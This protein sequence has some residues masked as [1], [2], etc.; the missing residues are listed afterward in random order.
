M[1]ILQANCDKG[2]LD[3]LV[4]STGDDGTKEQ[5]CVYDLAKL[6]GAPA[7]TSEEFRITERF[8]P[9]QLGYISSCRCGVGC[10]EIIVSSEEKEARR[11]VELITDIK[12][13]LKKLGGKS[14][15]AD[16][17]V[18]ERLRKLDSTGSVTI[19][20]GT[21]DI[22]RGKLSV[23]ETVSIIGAWS[24]SLRSRSIET[25]VGILPVAL[26]DKACRTLIAMKKRVSN[27][28]LWIDSLNSPLR[29]TP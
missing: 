6:A 22:A 3:V 27:V 10:V 7:V 23:E 17:A 28:G 4:V 26:L 19:H 5:Y 18:E 11:H 2:L 14:Y 8:S 16:L 15:E 21:R 24:Y 20:L 25:E 29:T 1:A 13:T 9:D 12:E